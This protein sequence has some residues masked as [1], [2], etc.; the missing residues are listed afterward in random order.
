MC[1]AYAY[2]IDSYPNGYMMPRNYVEYMRRLKKSLHNAYMNDWTGHGNEK[3]HT[4]KTHHREMKNKLHSYKAFDDFD[5]GFGLL[6][7]PGFSTGIFLRSP[8]ATQMELESVAGKDVPDIQITMFP[9][10]C[11]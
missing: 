11:E 5:S 9:S 7:S 4:Q 3:E 6:G 2:F 1:I 8:Y 10:V